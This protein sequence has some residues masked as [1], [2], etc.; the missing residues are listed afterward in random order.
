M[1]TITAFG[2][3]LNTT[4][5]THNVTAAGTTLGDLI[6]I[7]TANTGN[8]SSAR[9]TDDQ[10]GTYVEVTACAC[11]KTTSADQMRVFVRT[12]LIQSTVSTIYTHAPGTST[13]GGLQVFAVRG[14][15]RTGTNAV[16]QGA[17][18]DNQAAAGTPTPVLGSAALTGN[19]LIGAVFNDTNPATMTPRASPAWTEVSDVGYI[20]PTTGLETMKINSGETASSI[21]WGGT[22][23]TQFCSCVL[24]L[25]CSA[26]IA[27]D[28]L[29]QPYLPVGKVK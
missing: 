29:M 24:E 22:S 23:A 10:G 17:K 11:V 12:N 18:Q 2:S 28:I 27:A 14:L 25:D 15:A 6:V 9:P 16:R 21:A 19:A 8:T 1:A 5:G 26:E 20:T 4:S 3:T 7:V 13:G